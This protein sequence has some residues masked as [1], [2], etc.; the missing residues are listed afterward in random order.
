[1]I[2]LFGAG[3]IMFLSFIMDSFACFTD[4]AEGSG[5]H[6]RG[7]FNDHVT[8]TASPRTGGLD[9]PIKFWSG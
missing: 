5:K 7:F 9:F 4:Y 1:M 3:I 2:V 8:K 6:C